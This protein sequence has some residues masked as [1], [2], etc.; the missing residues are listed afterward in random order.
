M[1]EKGMKD[2]HFSI[3]PNRSNKQQALEVMKQ[4]NEVGIRTLNV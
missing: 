4:L 3:K 1:I 2:L